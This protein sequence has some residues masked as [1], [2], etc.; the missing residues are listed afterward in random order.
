[1]AEH[2]TWRGR[3]LLCAGCYRARE[4]VVQRLSEFS[5]GCFKSGH[6]AAAF[7]SSRQSSVPHVAWLQWSWDIS[8]HAATVDYPVHASLC[9]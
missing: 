1:M 3:H 7:S 2:S 5:G 8:D 6:A 4:E 9:S